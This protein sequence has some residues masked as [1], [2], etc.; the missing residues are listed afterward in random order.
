[1]QLRLNSFSLHKFLKLAEPFQMQLCFSEE[2]RP[3]SSRLE[4]RGGG[5]GAGACAAVGI[6]L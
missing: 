6:H 3:L 4:L 5:A 1:M 2:W